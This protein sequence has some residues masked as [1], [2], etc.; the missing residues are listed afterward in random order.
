MFLCLLNKRQNGLSVFGVSTCSQKY[1]GYLHATWCLNGPYPRGPTRR[2]SWVL[3]LRPFAPLKLTNGP[4]KGWHPS[5]QI[6]WS[7]Y[8][9][10]NA[11]VHIVIEVVKNKN[12]G[13]TCL[14]L[15]VV[16]TW[17]LGKGFIFVKNVSVCGSK[18]LVCTDV[19]NAP[20]PATWKDGLKVRRFGNCS[21]YKSPTSMDF[22][23]VCLDVTIRK[24][25]LILG[26]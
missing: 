25:L 5:Y 12:V 17:L 9:V 19:Q 18:G 8:V 26:I 6:L 2:L 7:Q 16:C 20:S 4:L 24:L 22:Q 15:M 3:Y 13:S 14:N 21:N 11:F 23:C 1:L 10:G